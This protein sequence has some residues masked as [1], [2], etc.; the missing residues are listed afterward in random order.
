MEGNI[1]TRGLASAFDS[2]TF[3]ENVSFRLDK[4]V[5]SASISPCGRDIVLASRQGLH[6]IDL[7]SP[8]S[9]P[10]HLS[11]HTPWEVADVQWSPFA[12]R[13]Y[14]VVS[15]SNQKA[16]VWNLEMKD[17]R[18]S[19]EHYLH[20]HTRAITDINFSAHHP[21]ILATCAVDSY[22]HCWDLRR[23]SRAAMT[24]C[25]WFAGA[26][27]VKWNRQDSHILA[28]SHD[29]FLR[30][31]DDRKGAYPLRSIEAHAT[32]IYGVD[33]NRT[34]TNNVATCSLDRTIKFWDYTSRS[35]TPER[36][37][38]TPFPVW[39]ARHTPFGAGLLAMPQRND[40]DLHLYDRRPSDQMQQPDSMPMVHRFDGHEDQ[41]KEFLWRA[42]GSVEDST[43]SR[44]F[45]L[46]SWGTDRVLQLH[47]LGEDILAKVGHVRGH[48][49]KQT[50]PFTR[51]NAP[52]KSFRGDP[53][54]ITKD[55]DSIF[56]PSRHNLNIQHNAGMSGL[57]GIDHSR[58]AL[59]VNAAWVTTENS[60][61]SMA[62]KKA[63]S[64]DDVDAISWMKGVKIGKRE[65]RQAGVDQSMSSVLSPALKT[66][67][68]WD[69][70]DSLAEEIT[71]LADKFS[72]VTF[73]NINMDDRQIVLSLHGPWGSGRASVFVKCSIEVP[74]RYPNVEPP[75]VTIES[76]AEMTDESILQATSEVQL[77][78][79]AYQERHRHSLEAILRYLLG[80]QSYDDTLALLQALPD[81]SGLGLDGQGELSSSDDDEES[82][83][84]YANIQVPGLESSDA[85]IAISNAQYNVPLPN[86]CGAL[87]ADDGRL[88]CFFPPKEERP[89]S[90][91]QPLNFKAGEWTSKNRRSVLEGFGKLQSG[92][93]ISKMASSK[94]S[95]TESGDSD[96]DDSSES[97]SD[98]SSSTENRT[99]H[100]RLMPTMAW[101][102][103]IHESTRALSVDESQRSSGP[104]GLPKSTML[105][106]KNFVSIRDCAELL[107][108]KRAL[109]VEYRVDSTGECCVHNAAV[110]RKYGELDLADIWES[111]NLI[112]QDEVPLERI[113]ISSKYDPI[114]VVARRAVSPL[115]P[116]DSAIDLSYDSH[117]EEHKTELKGRVYWGAH[118]F[119]SRWLVEAL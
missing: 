63:R 115:H 66:S 86:A 65:P 74:L 44:D 72:K 25:D 70:F 42:R 11:H 22:V 51:R 40:Y 61:A 71:H 85:M 55:V 75:W 43:D 36:T 108:A 64:R 103:G 80:E 57:S 113:H 77:I 33:W 114:L 5:G 101:R 98:S 95:A 29:K 38:H 83:H 76:T 119:G 110:A 21:D 4:P 58:Q 93:S 3:E 45:Q 15:T 23:P 41:V 7:D 35:D 79:Q 59:G 94:I 96:F 50:I 34:E 2:P 8:W 12:A 60:L 104:S 37:I 49:V 30:I 16:L 6:I 81:R 1:S 78:A 105:N 19:I 54:S 107:P 67:Q 88:V 56:G 92:S 69:T 118:P 47:R 102:E 32:K 10:R 97:S 62:G 117:E 46:V 90:F 53:S 100:L 68:P 39:R 26:T 24:F 52:Y 112:I 111:L 99:S 91:M 31:W 28:S 109:A 48:Q 106:S 14:W 27:Q 73:E 116:K 87:W 17:S 89:P 13:D 84:Q 9:P 20:A 18:A 82:D